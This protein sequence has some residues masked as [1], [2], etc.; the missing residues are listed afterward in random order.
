M[1]HFK[2]LHLTYIAPFALRILLYGKDNIIWLKKQEERQLK[3]LLWFK[4]VAYFQRTWISQ[5]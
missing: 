2:M 1:S 3:R 4:K 5:G